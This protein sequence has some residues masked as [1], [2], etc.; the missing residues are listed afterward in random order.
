VGGKQII[1]LGKKSSV[2]D[3]LFVA[4]NGLEKKDLTLVISVACVTKHKH[5]LT[6]M[7]LMLNGEHIGGIVQSVLFIM[8]G[9]D[10][11]Y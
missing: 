8:H 6:R 5:I 7:L 1:F 11:F 10:S 3:K 4:F 9:F 2:N